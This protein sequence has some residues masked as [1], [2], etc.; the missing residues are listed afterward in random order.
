MYAIRRVEM[1]VD[2]LRQ[3]SNVACIGAYDMY[4]VYMRAGVCAY[5]TSK[6]AGTSSGFDIIDARGL[7]IAHLYMY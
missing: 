6:Q 7:L 2:S 3:N 4:T 5:M 1:S